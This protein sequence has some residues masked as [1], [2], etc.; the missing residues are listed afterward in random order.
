MGTQR[1][2]WEN[3][4]NE[5]RETVEAHMGRVIK[6]EPVEAGFN[7]GLAAILHTLN[8][9]VFVKGLPVNDRKAWTQDREALIAPNV[10]DIAP[11]LLWRVQAGGWDLIGYEHI[12]GRH[13]DY[14]PGSADLAL[15]ADALA[16]LGKAVLPTAFPAKTEE[17]WR[18]YVD[19]PRDLGRLAGNALLHTD[20]NPTNLLIA[21]GRA[22]VV[23]WAWPTRAAGWIDAA[24]WVVWL[25]VAGHDPAGAERHAS[26][27]PAWQHAHTSDLDLFARIQ[28]RLWAGIAEDDPD[29]W[30][31]GVALAAARWEEHRN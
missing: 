8:R 27:V 10:I 24:G 7:S 11:R 5:A 21:H 19:T 28:S 6:A 2:Q 22:Y 3:L 20:L 1:Q 13:A 15:V 29:P 26:A 16:T 23:D 12:D 14:I 31:E 17:R 18:A 4:P 9:S 30:A 25:I